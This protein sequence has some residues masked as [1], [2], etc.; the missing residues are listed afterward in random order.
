M[1]TIKLL[2]MVALLLPNAI[3]AAI[4]PTAQKPTQQIITAASLSTLNRIKVPGESPAY[5]CSDPSHDLFKIRRFDFIP[6]NP[7]MYDSFPRPCV[8]FEPRC[9]ELKLI[10]LVAIPKP[11]ASL[12][13]SS[14]PP[15]TSPGSMSPAVSMDVPSQSRCIIHHSATST[16]S[17]KSLS[18]VLQVTMIKNLA[19]IAPVRP[20]SKK[21][22]HS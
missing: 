13:T 1:Q 14:L 22:T 19:F 17:K 15:A 9:S 18:R 12:A 16:Y 2:F 8:L 21:A 6:I 10:P 20:I 7:R 5:F 11:S 3:L 4:W